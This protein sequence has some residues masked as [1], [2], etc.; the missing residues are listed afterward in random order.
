MNNNLRFSGE[1]PK[2]IED[3]SLNESMTEATESALGEMIPK[4]SRS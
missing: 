1:V 3:P 2:P 4:I